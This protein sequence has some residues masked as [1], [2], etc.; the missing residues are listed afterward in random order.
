MSIEG[1]DDTEL[2]DLVATTLQSSGILGK[3]KVKN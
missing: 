2:R 1:D 3:I